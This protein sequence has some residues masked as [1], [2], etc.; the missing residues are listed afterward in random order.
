[1][2]L[3]TLSINWYSYCGREIATDAIVWL[4]AAFCNQGGGV[5]GLTAPPGP[6][7]IIDEQ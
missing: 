3:E 5:Y 4:R 1:M 2:Y 7:E 6:K